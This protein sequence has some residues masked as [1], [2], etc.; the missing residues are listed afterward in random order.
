MNEATPR[1]VLG[2]SSSSSRIDTSDTKILEKFYKKNNF[3]SCSIQS[4]ANIMISV[5]DQANPKDRDTFVLPSISK[6]TSP[7]FDEERRNI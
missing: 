6:D 2:S 4:D 5:K 3:N 7:K 1:T